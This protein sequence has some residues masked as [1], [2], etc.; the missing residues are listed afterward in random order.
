MDIP[1]RRGLSSVHR[2]PLQ[3]GQQKW[4]KSSLPRRFSKRLNFRP[5]TSLRVLYQGPSQFGHSQLRS[6]PVSRRGRGSGITWR[7]VSGIFSFAIPG[8]S[9]FIML[10]RKLRG[11]ESSGIEV[12]GNSRFSS[13]KNSNLVWA[14]RDFLDFF[15]GNVHILA[16]GGM[17]AHPSGRLRIP[18]YLP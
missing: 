17:D 8:F 5:S 12:R 6:S 13:R 7:A 15:L 2:C 14:K 10:T 18:A 11:G 1:T 9:T 3:I 16:W 4:G